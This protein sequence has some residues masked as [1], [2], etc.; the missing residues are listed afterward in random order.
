M[1]FSST[2]QTLKSLV[3]WPFLFPTG[4]L[5]TL[6]VNNAARVISDRNISLTNIWWHPLADLRKASRKK[7]PCPFLCDFPLN[8]HNHLPWVLPF[9]HPHPHPQYIISW[10]KPCKRPL[11]GRTICQLFTPGVFCRT[12]LSCPA[13]P[14][15]SLKKKSDG[16]SN[17]N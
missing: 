5:H 11:A 8:W 16:L 6:V 9:S 3:V 15:G 7:S 13:R 12:K 4:D 10:H 17:I 2:Q 14:S 1:N